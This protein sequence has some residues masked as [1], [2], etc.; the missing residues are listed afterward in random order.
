MTKKHKEPTDKRGHSIFVFVFLVWL[1]FKTSGYLRLDS[2]IN[3]PGFTV[4]V[5]GNS[6]MFQTGT[7]GPLLVVWPQSAH[8]PWPAQQLRKGSP[9]LT[10]GHPQC[11]EL[12]NTPTPSSC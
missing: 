7:G 6:R 4:Q 8:P 1:A 10:S 2:S 12:T 11:L 3:F 5:K 9:C